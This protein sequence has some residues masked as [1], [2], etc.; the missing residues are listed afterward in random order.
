MQ[1]KRKSSRPKITIVGAGFVGAT[2]AHWAVSKQLGDV[3][4][5][6]IAGE[7]AGGKA[8]DL[9]EA[10]PVDGLNSI[11]VG[12]SDYSLSENSEVV[13]I[14]AGLPRKPG[15]SRD[16]LLATN[17]KIVT[18]VTQNVA[19]YSPNAT[20]IVVSNPLD[21]MAQIVKDVSG[22]PRSRVIGMAGILDTS[23][24]KT[25]IADELDVSVK[26]VHAFV[27]G[28]HGDTM[29]P[30]PRYVSVGGVPLEQMLPQEKIEEL[31]DRARKGGAEIVNYLKTGSAFFAPSASVIEMVEAILRDQK[32]ILPCACYLEGEY[33]VDGLF[34]GVLGKLGKG[35]LEKVVEI[36]MNEEEKSAFGKSVDAVKELVDSWNKIKG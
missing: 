20:I 1:S 15:M 17:G 10:T 14:T 12:G 25:F 36:E 7:M 24:F 3:V 18:E 8:L 32:R 23:R 2:A 16:D 31:V 28:G 30:M 35:G 22:F 11:V 21:A 29:V 33:G 34:I 19:K 27:F 9:L 6:D 4:L 13:V 26:D 5:I